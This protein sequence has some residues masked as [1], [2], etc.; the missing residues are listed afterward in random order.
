MKKT[1]W[2][3]LGICLG[4]L[5]VAMDWSIVNNALPSIQRDLGATLGELQWMVNVFGLVMTVSLVTMGGFADAFGRRKLFSLGLLTCAL[6]SLGAALAPNA[7]WLIIFRAVQGLSN[8]MLLPTSQSLITHVFPESQHGKAMGIWTTL[9]GLGLSLGPVL[10]GVI[11]AISSWHWIFYFNLPFLLVSWILVRLF[12]EDSK[13]EQQSAKM[14][15]P[16][17]FLLVIGL[18]SLIL[19]VVQAPDWGWDAP[20]TIALV[21]L[22]IVGLLLFYFVEKRVPSPLIKFEFFKKKKFLAAALGNFSIVFLFWGIFFSV[23]L[24]LQNILGETPFRSGMF[25][26]SVTIPFGVCSHYAGKYADQ[27]DKKHLLMGGLFL[28][29]LG[30]FSMTFFSDVKW[31]F[32]IIASLGL[33]GVGSGTIFGPSTSLGISAIPRN[34]AG[35]ASGVLTTMQEIGGS[36]GLALTGTFLR[37]L[38]QTKLNYTLHQQG[39]SLSPYIQTKVRSLLSSFEHLKEYLSHQNADVQRKVMEA[40]QEAFVFGFQGGMWLCVAVSVCSIL[41]I[42]FLLKTAE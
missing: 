2:P 4:V 38:E 31:N 37:S 19:A 36:V 26:L 41:M 33:F 17:L 13:N 27:I 6:G 10:G 39:M 1:L 9:V 11:I 20:I 32:L 18:G 3:S 34:F 12:V 14:D 22:A 7:M 25:M 16:G 15:V 42:F 24:Y 23:P 40:F 30:V 35:V 21:T 5:V 28:A 29:F 8:A